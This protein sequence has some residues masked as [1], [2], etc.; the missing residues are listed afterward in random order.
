MENEP[1]LY[2]LNGFQLQMTED[3]LY[4][5]V[6]SRTLPDGK[7]TEFVLAIDDTETILRLSENLL[8]LALHR[9]DVSDFAQTLAGAKELLSRFLAQTN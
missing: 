1:T 2:Y 8:Q 7:E 9:N 6:K 5:D 3:V 4:V